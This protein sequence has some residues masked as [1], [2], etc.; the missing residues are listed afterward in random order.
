MHK[1]GLIAL[2]LLDC[3]NEFAFEAVKFDQIAPYET[4]WLGLVGK[5][6]MVNKSTH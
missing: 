6:I 2:I 4:K 5:L 1:S 3:K